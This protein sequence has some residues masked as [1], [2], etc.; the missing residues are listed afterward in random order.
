[1]WGLW[2]IHMERFSRQLDKEVRRA[3]EMFEP[4]DLGATGI[5]GIVYPMCLNRR[6]K[7]GQEIRAVS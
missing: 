4:R 5:S 1:M 2:M 7:E 6:A 3:V